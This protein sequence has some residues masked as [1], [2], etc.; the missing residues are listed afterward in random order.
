MM[1][2]L[3]GAE[4]SLNKT[5][6]DS[7]QTDVN[8]SLGGYISSS[9]V[10]NG[11]INTLFDYIS[12]FTE[13]KKQKE[14]IAIALINKFDVA[15]T[16]VELKILTDVDNY[17]LF[18]VCA[19]KV[20]ND[21]VMEKINNRYQ[22]PINAEFFDASFCRASVDLKIERPA[23]IGEEI[24]LFPFNINFSVLKEGIEG[25]WEAFEEAFSN[26]ST[27]SIKRLSEYVFRI[28]RKD[29]NIVET[30]LKCSYIATENFSA[31]FLGDF[32][33]ALKGSVLISE[34]I[35]PNECIG[36]W[37]QRQIKKTNY[38]TNEE[39]IENYKEKIILDK[40]EE[41]ELIFNYDL[42]EKQ[43]NYNEETYNEQYS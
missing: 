23:S 17:A 13:E 33:N 35:K 32:S 29:E 42:V 36:I 8:K 21:Y 1:I 5:G 16:N 14:T 3:T 15:V 39:L 27:Y 43:N 9:P 22:E 41:V 4:T 25:T 7:P 24:A 38:K 28:E 30:P 12:S 2:Y 34:E 37:L 40:I 11:A 10:P 31:S 26:D 18:R 20:N 19:V 6:G